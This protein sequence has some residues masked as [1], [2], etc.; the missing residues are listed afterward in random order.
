MDAKTADVARERISFEGRDGNV[1]AAD[2]HPSTQSPARGIVLMVHGG[3]Q[4]R[5]SWRGSSNLLAESGWTAITMDQ[6][7]HGDSAWADD[8][9]YDFL[10]FSEDLTAVADQITERYG[11]RPVLVGASLGGIAGMLAE[12]ENARDVLSAVILVDVTPRLRLAGVVKILGFMSERAEDG[13]ASLEEAADA[14]ARY[15]PNRPKRTDTSGLAKNLRQGEDGRYRWHWD[16]RFLDSRRRHGTPEARGELQ[17]QLE[18]AVRAISVPLMLV[19]GRQSELVD[20]EMVD[21]FLALAPHAKVADVSEAGHMVAGDKND[22][23]TSAV[24]A[25][26]NEI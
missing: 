15:L 1:I 16:P 7:G 23:F 17:K 21:E 9:D 5:H 6:R 12:G 2:L 19:R 25:F 4:T 14:I 20:D 24:L 18:D 13:F 8:G 10:A 11:S 26:L 3:G 22:V